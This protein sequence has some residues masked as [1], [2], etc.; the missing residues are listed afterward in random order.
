M[1]KERVTREEHAPKQICPNL[2]MNFKGRCLQITDNVTISVYF[3]WLSSK[4][5]INIL[6]YSLLCCAVAYVFDFTVT[7]TV[8]IVPI[9]FLSY[10]K[11]RLIVHV[12]KVWL[13]KEILWTRSSDSSMHFLLLFCIYLKAASLPIMLVASSENRSFI[14]LPNRISLI[15]HIN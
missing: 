11:K 12:R 4:Q 2:H 5:T 3:Q 15:K 7:M 13:S 14:L 9:I 10:A 6:Y 8:N 1:W